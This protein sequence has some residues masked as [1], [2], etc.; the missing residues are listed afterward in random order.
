MEEWRYSSIILDLGTR[1]SSVVSF[2][3]RPL[4]PRGRRHRYSLDRALGGPYVWSGRL[5]GTEKSLA[6]PGIEPQPSLYRLSYLGSP[7]IPTKLK[8]NSVAFSP[9]ANYTDRATASCRRS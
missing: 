1:W 9:Q 3:P 6:L 8:L 4:Y 2:T 5:W 7:Q